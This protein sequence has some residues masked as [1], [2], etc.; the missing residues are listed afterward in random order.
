MGKEIPKGAEI[1]DKESREVIE[2]LEKEGH[3]FEDIPGDPPKE[4]TPKEEKPDKVEEETKKDIPEDKPLDKKPE[5]EKEPEE[6]EKTERQAREPAWKQKMKERRD[7]QGDKLIL[8]KLDS[9]EKELK[10]GKSEKPSEVEDKRAEKIKA[11]K[12]KYEGELSSELLDEII[13]LMPKDPEKFEL[14][15]EVKTKLAD[16][17]KLKTDKTTEKEDYEYVDIFTEKVLPLL[18]ADFPQATQEDIKAVKDRLKGH[19]F[20][21]RYINLP[22]EK[23]YN[24]ERNDLSRQISPETRKTAEKAKKGLSKGG[25]VVDYENITAEQMKDLPMKEQEKALE[26]LSKKSKL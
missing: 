16:L 7:R 11:I 12:E 25:E 14:P 26:A 4:E 23:V 24:A 21:E 13:G 15:E 2:S 10:K 18:K 1:P 20:D 6:P 3:T 19:Y 9:L 22:V 8:E 5:V 17:E